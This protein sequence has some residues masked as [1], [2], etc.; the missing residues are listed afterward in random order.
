MV[1]AEK[2]ANRGERSKRERDFGTKLGKALQDR[3][4][5]PEEYETE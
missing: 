3:R 1:E 5:V 2:N 4:Y